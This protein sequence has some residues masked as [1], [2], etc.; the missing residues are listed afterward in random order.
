VFAARAR[1]RALVPALT[2]AHGGGP[3]LAVIVQSATDRH[4]ESAASVIRGEFPRVQFL[5]RLAWDVAGA[6]I[7][8]GQHVSRPERTMLVRSGRDL[9]TALDGALYGVELLRTSSRPHNEED[10]PAAGVP[11]PTAAS[12][13]EP[14]RIRSAEHAGLRSRLGS[15]LGHRRTG[16][17][18]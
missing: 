3:Q 17:A 16:E 9:V 18:T 10:D 6:R 7:F 11:A 2:D 4:A 15:R 1:L 12:A 5:G 14:R 13:P 8:D